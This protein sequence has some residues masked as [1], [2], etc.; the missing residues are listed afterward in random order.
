MNYFTD[1]ALKGLSWTVCNDE[2]WSDR[3]KKIIKA[4]EDN[5]LRDKVKVIV[6][7]AAVNAEKARTLVGADAYASD[8][9]ERAGVSLFLDVV[10]ETAVA[11]RNYLDFVIKCTSLPFLIDASSDVVRLAGLKTAKKHS[12]MKRVVYN[13][14]GVDTTKSAIEFVAPAVWGCQCI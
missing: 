14:I 12:M 4:L 3:G 9:A 1:F 13:S 7:G 2:F 6:G 5:K 8:A 11:M 10:A